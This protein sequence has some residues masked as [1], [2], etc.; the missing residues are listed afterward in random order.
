[1]TDQLLR[2]VGPTVH[3][4]GTSREELLRQYVD[5]LNAHDGALEPLRQAQPHMRDYAA[6]DFEAVIQQHRGR[7]D[8]LKD[9]RDDQPIRRTPTAMTRRSIDQV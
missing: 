8:R 4:N 2:L 5:A 9:V 7:V 3:T 1:M 6:A